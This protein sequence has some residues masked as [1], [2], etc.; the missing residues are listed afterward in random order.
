MERES[1]SGTLRVA[2]FD[3]LVL[4]VENVEE[5]ARFYA[6]VCG[7][8]R[9]TFDDTRVAMH[10]GDQKL[11]LDPRR[12]DEPQPSGADFCLVTDTGPDEVVNHLRQLGVRI[13]AGPVRRHG[14]CGPMISVYVLDPDGNIVE[15][16]SYAAP[17]A[18]AEGS[19]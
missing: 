18:D 4:M 19:R 9:R 1:A 10:F 3:H 12:A 8:E 15:L 17:L 13:G 7:M 16:A 14:A 11:N 2:R 6:E 5:S